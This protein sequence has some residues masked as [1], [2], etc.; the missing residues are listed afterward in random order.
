MNLSANGAPCVTILITTRNRPQELI[1]TVR[2][3]HNQDYS[4]LH[5]MVIDDNSDIPLEPTV[6]REWPGA[7]VMRNNTTLGYIACRSLGMRLAGGDY[8]LSLDDDSCLTDPQDISRAVARLAESPQLGILTFRVHNGQTLENERLES[9]ERYV[10]TFIGCGHLIRR[11][12][13]D[14]IGGY[15]DFYNYY[16]EE[17]EYALRALDAGW[18]ILFFPTVLV[19]H[20]VSSIG[21]RPGRIYGYSLRNNIWTAI[22]RLPVTRLPFELLW[23]AFLG[24]W[25]AIR[26]LEVKWFAWAVWSVCVS[27]PRVLR[28]RRPVSPETMRLYDHLRFGADNQ[29]SESA[30][31]KAPSWRQLWNW[32]FSNWRMRRRARAFWD[33]RPGGTGHAPLATFSSDGPHDSPSD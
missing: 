23:K 25:E 18:R 1:A 22:L 31:L 27:L 26:L 15:C 2:E 10:H 3:L 14:H 30:T 20:R 5:L 28:L 16:A 17:P 29:Q 19:H 12:V 32:F 6:F 9:A 8:L 7:T 33:R 13:S 11:S 4:P 24:L 21:R